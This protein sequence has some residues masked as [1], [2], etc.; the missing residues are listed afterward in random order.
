MNRAAVVGL[1]AILAFFALYTSPAV[2]LDRVRIGSSSSGVSPNNGAIYA[3]E[4]KGLFKKHGIEVEVI[5]IGGGAARGVSALVAGDIQFLGGGGAAAIS[6]ALKGA[7]LMLVASV[8]NK[9]IQ[10]VMARPDVK[11]PA[12]LKGKKIGI[13]RFGSASHT[14]LQI[15]LRRWDITPSEVQVIQVGSSPAMLTS[16]DKGWI[17]AAVLTVPSIF[18]AEDKGYR[19][20][21][22]LA[23]LDIDYL[24]EAMVSKQSY[25]R[26]HRDQATRFIKGYIEGIAYFKRNKK[27]SVEVLRR[28]LRMEPGREDRYLARMYD[29]YAG[30]YFDKVP[31]PSLKGVE[32]VL[33][34]LA[35]EEP[36]AKGADPK[37]F[38][39]SSIVRELEASGFINSLYEN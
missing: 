36:K 5:E 7:D 28:K 30:K 39:D 31:Y 38:L 6:A 1:S 16:L 9:G 25:L 27:E 33:E 11:S 34:F 18:V 24:H 17:D 10:R 37:S 35:K 32:T 12:D 23:D 3:A 2:S 26:S 22:D 20:L 4:L 29:L 8:L 15:M 13:S 21:A 14:V 19:V